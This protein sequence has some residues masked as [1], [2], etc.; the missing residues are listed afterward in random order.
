LASGSGAGVASC[1]NHEKKKVET[2]DA[3]TMTDPGLLP[4]PPGLLHALAS[5]QEEVLEARRT[6]ME[7][8]SWIAAEEM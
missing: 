4:P 6:E 7:T 3:S 8:V 1:S 2:R 5:I